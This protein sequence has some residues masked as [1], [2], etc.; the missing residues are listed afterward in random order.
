VRP[1]C[2]STTG[3]L[4]TS[5]ITGDTPGESRVI[6]LLITK[7]RGPASPTSPVARPT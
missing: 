2:T 6:T 1:T 3:E 7:G 4:I 5:M